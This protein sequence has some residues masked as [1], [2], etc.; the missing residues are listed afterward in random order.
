LVGVFVA[1][2][3]NGVRVA[4]TGAAP[5]V[6][7]VKALE[8][9]LAKSWTAEAARAVKVSPSGLNNDLHGSPDYRAHLVSVM[10]ARAVA[11]S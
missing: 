11:A 2:T 3:A 7:R 10:A 6:M 5:S 8:D 4:V 1:K 9:A